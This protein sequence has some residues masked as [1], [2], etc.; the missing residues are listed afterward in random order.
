MTTAEVPSDHED[1]GDDPNGK[2]QITSYQDGFLDQV[3]EALAAGFL[4]GDDVTPEYLPD[5]EQEGVW[6]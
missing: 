6:A 1:H 2:A 4:P 5:A 3:S